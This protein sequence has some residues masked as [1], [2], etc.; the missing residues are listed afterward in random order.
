[1]KKYIISFIIQQSLSL[2]GAV[3]PCFVVESSHF[4]HLILLN[5]LFLLAPPKT[6]LLDLGG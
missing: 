3:L 6:V 5:L 2:C 4:S 1:M